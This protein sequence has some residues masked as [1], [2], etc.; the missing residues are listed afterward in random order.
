[1]G[2]DWGRY[3]EVLT[4]NTDCRKFDDMLRMV[5][6]GTADQR[7]ALDEYLQGRRAA[8]RLVYGVHCAPRA[9]MTCMVFS[10]SGEH[11]HFV[12]GADGGYA[13]AAKGLKAQLRGEA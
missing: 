11:I 12:D 10:Y 8:G 7:A 9:L 1:M 2:T 3:K 13:L 5:I 4:A 6:S